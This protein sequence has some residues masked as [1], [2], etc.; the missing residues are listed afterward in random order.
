MIEKDGFDFSFNPLA[1]NSCEGNCCRGESGYIWV[2]YSEIEKIAKVLDM[3]LEDFAKIYLR[4]VGHRYS[5][6]ERKLGDGDFG[7]IFFDE[8][9]RACKIYEARPLQCRTYPFWDSFKS[10][11]SQKELRTECP[12]VIWKE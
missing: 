6:V 12:G 2:K 7:C 5:L 3:S 11:E 1:C 10:K 8:V 9:K 4:K